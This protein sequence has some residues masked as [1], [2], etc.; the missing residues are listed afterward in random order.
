MIFASKQKFHY[1]F[2]LEAKTVI[3]TIS[4]Q[5]SVADPERFDA[6]PDPTFHADADP[7]PNF[8]SSGEKKNVLQNLQIFFTKSY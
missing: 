7:D 1:E 2:C 5:N 4:L 8:C 3:L 6:D